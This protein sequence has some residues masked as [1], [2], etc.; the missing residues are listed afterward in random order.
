MSSHAISVSNGHDASLVIAITTIVLVLAI[1]SY[2]FRL[3]GRWIAGAKLWYDDY[4]MGL[5]LILGSLCCVCNYLSLKVG[6]GQHVRSLTETDIEDYLIIIFALQLISLFTALFNKIGI[7]LFYWRIFPGRNFHMSI[8]AVGIY[9]VLYSIGSAVA[10]IF[11]CTPVQ[12][13]WHQTAT[14][15]CVNQ[16]SLYIATGALN[17]FSDV[18]ILLMPLPVLMSLQLAR[19]RK[20]AL[21]FVFS[22]GGFVCIVSVCRII[23]LTKIVRA[24]FTYSNVSSALW[25]AVEAQIGVVCANLPSTRPLFPWVIAKAST[26]QSFSTMVRSFRSRPKGFSNVSDHRNRSDPA[27]QSVE[28]ITYHTKDDE[29]SQTDIELPQYSIGVTTTTKVEQD[30]ARRNEDPA[31][32][33]EYGW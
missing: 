10:F 12:G 31:L 19:Q 14:T 2:I 7:L 21:L 13:F 23:F 28:H 1:V 18:F 15:T 29:H 24:D 32:A 11:Q 3:C 8:W 22:L 26:N 4:V 25:S 16:N 27:T 17:T 6:L 33:K 20:V 5:A 30:M 9:V